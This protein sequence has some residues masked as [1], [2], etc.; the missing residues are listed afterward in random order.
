MRYLYGI[1]MTATREWEHKSFIKHRAAQD[2]ILAWQEFIAEFEYDGSK[3]LKFEQLEAQIQVPYSQSEP[4]GMLAYI[5]KFQATM[6]QLEVMDPD[7]SK[8]EKMKRML[9][10]NIRNATGITHLIQ[11]CKDDEDWSYAKTAAYL[12]KNCIL[13]DRANTKKAPTRLMHFMDPNIPVMGL[14][15]T[16]K[17]FTTMVE[18]SGLE[19]TYRVFNART[20][21]DRLGIPAAIWNKM[22][23]AICEKVDEIRAK[24]KKQRPATPPRSN[25]SDIPAQYPTMKPQNSMANL[26][27]SIGDIGSG[28]DSDTDDD[29]LQTS[30]YMVKQ[31]ASIDALPDIDNNL[32]VR[33]QPHMDPPSDV[34]D[35]KAHFEYRDNPNFKDVIYAISDGGADSCILDMNAKV[36]SYIG[37]YANMVGYDPKDRKN[38]NCDSTH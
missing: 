37:R 29:I 12:R 34:I 16:A 3:E 19:A 23:P 24:L 5:D 17:I 14:E 33:L 25:R 18:E 7:Y 2:G 15:D 31:R 1:L 28:E 20:F 35:V 4:G 30:A 11:N 32:E 27:N 13:I 36:L 10:A 38:P 22:E 8:P 21:R 9:L 6:A 26:V